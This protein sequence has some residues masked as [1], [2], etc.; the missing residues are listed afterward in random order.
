MQHKNEHK[1]GC[2]KGIQSTINQI[3][4]YVQWSLTHYYYIVIVNWVTERDEMRE[5]RQV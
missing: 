1:I 4:I 2:E 3:I 5:R